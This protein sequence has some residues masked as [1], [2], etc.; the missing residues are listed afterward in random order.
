LPAK[1]LFDEMTWLE[2]KDA[3][4]QQRVVLVPMGTVEQHGHHLPLCVDNL[5]VGEV[6]KKAAELIPNEAVVMPPLSYGYNEHHKD[7]PGTIFVD[8]D[9]LI[10]HGFDVCRSVAYH[11][12]RKIVIVN[13]HGSNGPFAQIIAREVTNKTETICAA[14]DWWNLSKDTAARLRESE[15]PGGMAH[16]CELETSLLLYLRPDLVQMDKVQK[17]MNFQ[18]SNYIWWDLIGAS[19]GGKV[20]FMDH[21]SR[22]SKTG[23]MGDPTKATPEKGREVF[24]ATVKELAAFCKEFRA[25]EI[26]KRVDHHGVEDPAA[27][28]DW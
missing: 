4:R 24:E 9:H 27:F 22:M 10:G 26:R 7:F 28:S 11:G 5:I 15:T 14:V 25:R 19:V 1:I 18:K 13:G 2:I 3:V 16:A 23:T 8:T 21:F 17:D 6:C 12:F 20:S